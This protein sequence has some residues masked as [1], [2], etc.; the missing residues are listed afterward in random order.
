MTACLTAAIA[1]IADIRRLSDNPAV[2]ILILLSVT[3]LVCNL[4]YCG[5]RIVADARQSR[6]AQMSWGL[7][8]LSGSI[9]ALA[10]MVGATLASLAHY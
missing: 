9:I 8:A 1:P 2:L 4:I 6:L 3:L 5:Q 7:L 10:A